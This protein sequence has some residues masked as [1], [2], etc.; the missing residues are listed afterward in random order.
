MK[1]YYFYSHENQT[2]NHLESLKKNNCQVA[3]YSSGHIGRQIKKLL[4]SEH[5]VVSCFINGNYRLQSGFVDDIPLLDDRIFATKYP[6]T[7]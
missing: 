3:I 1:K 4:E 7:M 5:I 2:T 6:T